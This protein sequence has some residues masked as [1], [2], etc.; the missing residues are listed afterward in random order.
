MLTSAIPT[1]NCVVF[2]CGANRGDFSTWAAKRFN[3]TVYAFEADPEIAASFSVPGDVKVLN[4]AIAGR[5]GNAVLRRARM[6]CSS[7][8]F[9][10]EAVDDDTL[11]VPARTLESICQEYKI[12]RV[13]LLKL[14][15][16]GAEL[17]VLAEASPEFL[18][19]VD[20]ITCE[21]HD[22]L[23]SS[24][25]PRIRA[26]L[27]RMKREGFLVSSM[28]YWSYGDVI[29]LNKAVINC[30]LSLR[31][32][33]LAHKYALGVTRVLHRCLRRS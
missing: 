7:T 11:A 2:D 15:I 32:R 24:H 27:S 22:F 28:S 4:V 18:A 12:A 1:S 3:A 14:D 23:D 13:N 8:V 31:L 26:V 25:R 16:E 33:M 29:M 30:G 10:R 9:N 20:Q 6:Q 5:N 17:D 21:F 19:S